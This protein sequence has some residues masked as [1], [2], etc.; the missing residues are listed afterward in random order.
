LLPRHSW[1]NNPFVWNNDPPK[2]RVVMVS[3]TVASVTP[4]NGTFLFHSWDRNVERPSGVNGNGGWIGPI[5]HQP[6]VPTIAVVLQGE[7]GLTLHLTGAISKGYDKEAVPMLLGVGG[8]IK[9][10]PLVGSRP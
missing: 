10:I 9:P 4:L 7:P 6:T 8:A 2:G 5:P 3:R 1:Y